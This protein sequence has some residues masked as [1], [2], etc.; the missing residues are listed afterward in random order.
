MSN[1]AREARRQ[2]AQERGFTED[3]IRR[4]IDW[5]DRH[6]PEIFADDWHDAA[7]ERQWEEE[8]EQTS[9]KDAAD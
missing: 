6:V 1:S 3:Y 8:H 9:L 7:R 2:V 4:Q 5:F